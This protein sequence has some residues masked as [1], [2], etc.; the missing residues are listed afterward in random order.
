MHRK[1]RYVAIMQIRDNT[2]FAI[3]RGTNRY[4]YYPFFIYVRQEVIWL[5]DIFVFAKHVLYRTIK[6]KVIR[7]HIY[8]NIYIGQVRSYG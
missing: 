4:D 7:S 8:I 3:P 2:S 6:D 1:I 5:I